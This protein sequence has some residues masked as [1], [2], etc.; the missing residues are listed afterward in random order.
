M[1]TSTR[2][3]P[4]PPLSDATKVENAVA[5]FD[6]GHITLNKA[7]KLCD[8]AR[9]KVKRSVKVLYLVWKIIG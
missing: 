8:V 4:Q 1:P 5:L 2:S 9:R 3:A 6:E 7:S